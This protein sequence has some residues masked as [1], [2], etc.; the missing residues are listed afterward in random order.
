MEEL[1]S[2]GRDGVR[3]GKWKMVAHPAD[4]LPSRIEVAGTARDA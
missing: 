1:A 2:P 4:R 3:D